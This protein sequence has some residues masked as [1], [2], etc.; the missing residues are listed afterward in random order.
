MA[1]RLPATRE[2]GSVIAQTEMPPSDPTAVVGRRILAYIIDFVILAVLVVVLFANLASSEEQSSAFQA[3]LT[4]EL[5]NNNPDADYVC[6]NADT[7]VILIETGQFA[8]IGLITL[9]YGFVTHMLLPAITGF[10]PGKAMVGL[11]IVNQETFAK[12]GFGANF[13][14]WILWIVDSAPWCFPLVG[15]ITGL[16]SNGHRRVGDMAAKTVVIDRKWMDHPL[17]I[18]GVNAVAPL[19]PAP[20]GPGGL[21]FGTPPP[22]TAGSTIGATAPPPPSPGSYPTAPPVAPPI[23]PPP[24]SPTPPPPSPAA[25]PPPPSP[26]PPPPVVVPPPP[27][28]TP[29]PP[30]PATPTTPPIAPIASPNPPPPS[31]DATTSFAPPADETISPETPAADDPTAVHDVAPAPPA[32]EPPAPEATAAQPPPP[33]APAPA[34]RPG[35][36]APQWDAARDTYIQWDPE[37]SKWMEWSE[38]AG[39]WIPISQ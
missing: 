17:P 5:I 15:L 24:P 14:R 7:T 38:A 2:H 23:Q 28:T 20:G 35:V 37:L 16:S 22:P 19:M 3:E 13:L 39:A 8:L 34:P 1:T 18:A 32:P 21:P 9:L 11:R 26:T 36:D 30:A 6:I 10:S 25:A 27:A 31:D 4:C 29:P 12:A 33:A